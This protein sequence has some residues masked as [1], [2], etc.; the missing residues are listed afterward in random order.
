LP[1]THERSGNVGW[2]HKIIFCCCKDNIREITIRRR[3]ERNRKGMLE[4]GNKE[5]KDSRE[6]EGNVVMWRDRKDGENRTII[7]T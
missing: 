2:K 5:I 4:K 1:H 7:Q 6:R 3:N